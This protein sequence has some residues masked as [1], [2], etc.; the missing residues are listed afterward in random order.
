VHKYGNPTLEE[1]GLSI[2]QINE[3]YKE[4]IEK[5]DVGMQPQL[6]SPR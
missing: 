4:Y 6:Q 5:V 2:E 1:L 3:I